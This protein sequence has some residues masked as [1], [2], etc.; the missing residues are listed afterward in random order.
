LVNSPLPQLEAL[1]A[2]LEL[3]DFNRA[4]PRVEQYFNREKNY[5]TNRYELDDA[6][7]AEIRERWGDYIKAYGYE[8]TREGR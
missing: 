2:Q 5:K 7:R 8:R 6:R 1:Y 4:R 3:G